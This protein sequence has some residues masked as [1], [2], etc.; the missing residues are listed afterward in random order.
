M[1]GLSDLVIT[2]IGMRCSL[3]QDSPGSCAAI[4]AGI[5]RFSIWPPK[6]EP[7]E[8]AI[9]G[10]AVEPDCGD[11][12]WTEKFED[13]SA[14]PLLESLWSAGYADLVDQNSHHLKWALFLSIPPFD[15]EGVDEE[16]VAEFNEKA[17]DDLLFPIEIPDLRP[18]SN[19]HAGC[20]L[21]IGEAVEA[22]NSG[23]LDMCI[24]GGADSYLETEYVY[25][26]REQKRIK[27]GQ[28]T[29]GF[30]PGEAAGFV[31]IEKESHARKRNAPVLARI[32][33]VY[34]SM[35]SI[36]WDSTEPGRYR[37][38]PMV[39]RELISNSPCDPQKIN[40]VI[41]DLNGER[42]RFLEWAM[43]NNPAL[44]SLPP[45]WRLWCPADCIGDTGAATGAIHVNLAVQA[46]LRG[47]AFGQAVLI[48]N[49][50]E[51]GERAAML[52]YSET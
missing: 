39:L 23:E 3:G 31:V 7:D 1:S 32:T 12:D 34:S 18:F 43:T 16:N 41:N 11:S 29:A 37:A 45:D 38:M 28:T 9:I 51:S 2:G 35:E 50:S 4:R 20:L 44:S 33:P 36:A 48:A 17:S 6:S 52:V 21:G 13:L 8:D 25:S 15:R 30:I 47:Y 14:Q 49:A 40:R 10:A 46:I 27:T 19:G 24:V 5:S 22:L 26:L 42:W